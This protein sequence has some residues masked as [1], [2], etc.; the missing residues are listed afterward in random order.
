MI[1]N[2]FKAIFFVTSITAQGQNLFIGMT[3][4]FNL[5]YSQYFEPDLGT[6]RFPYEPVVSYGVHTGFKLK[7]KA[8][9]ELM[10]SYNQYT[11]IALIENPPLFPY[12]QGF[13]R[14]IVR[15]NGY[16]LGFYY[17]Q[18]VIKK[19]KWETNLK[20]G[21]G[22]NKLIFTNGHGGFVDSLEYK[23]IGGYDNW[24]Y[25][26]YFLTRNVNDRVNVFL[27]SGL[28]FNYNIVNG[29]SISINVSQQMGLNALFAGNILYELSPY[30]SIINAVQ[31]YGVSQSMGNATTFRISLLYHLKTFRQNKK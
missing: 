23:H 24:V 16:Q 31:V 30:S 15:G 29:I 14:K 6:I 3:S 17:Y 12:K 1:R 2:I 20:F 28:D 8:R 26:H 22:L 13:E 18:P 10:G 21:I 4:A 27:E 25:Y 9:F 7:N 5:Q 11:L 19:R